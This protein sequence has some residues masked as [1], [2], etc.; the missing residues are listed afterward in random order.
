MITNKK[1]SLIV[2]VYNTDLYLEACLASIETQHYQDF[3]IIL[4]NDG[5]TDQSDRMCVEF[6]RKHPDHCIL[7]TQTNKGQG[8]A[9]NTGI[10]LA[11]GHYIC[12]VDS[13]DLVLPDFL[14]VLIEKA[15]TKMSDV[16]VTDLVK[17]FESTGKTHVFKNIHYFSDDM[18]LNLMMSHPGPVAK[19]IRR[20]LIVEQ[21]L[22]FTEGKIYEDLV[23]NVRLSLCSDKI[24]YVPAPNY[25]YRVRS[26][27]TMTQ[28]VI[29]PKM[30][31]IYFV[32][33]E[34][35]NLLKKF[36]VEYEYLAIEHLLY[37]ASL[38]FLALENG[39][40]YVQRNVRLMKDKFPGWT[41]NPYFKKRNLKFR[42]VCYLIYLKKYVL[43]RW[44]LGM[45]GA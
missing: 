3:E 14:S 30:E 20:S 6:Q 5:S 13:D 16:V 43:V 26:Q 38:R 32:F 34:I 31:D 25:I 1:I 35:E 10:T 17:V 41:K 27:S 23:F 15:E 2:P 12:F 11:T 28:R 19:L 40:N 18:K 44:L 9:R 8:A 33:D 22:S 24:D 42:L 7:V 4:I 37:S 45:R 21:S 39:L 36:P 29:T